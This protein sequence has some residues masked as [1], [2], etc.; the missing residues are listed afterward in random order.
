MRITRRQALEV[1]GAAVAAMIAGSPSSSAARRTILPEA[2][3]VFYGADVDSDAFKNFQLVVLDPAYQRSIAPMQQAGA[4][5][6]GYVSLGEIASNSIFR[7]RLPKDASLL[8]EN[9]QWAESFIVDV[10]VPSWRSFV[11]DTMIP[12][13]LRRGFDGLFL[14]TVDSITYAEQRA[15]GSIEAGA[16]LIRA[17][18]KAYPNTPIMLNRGYGVLEHVVNSIDAVLAESMLTTFDCTINAHRWTTQS[19]IDWQLAQLAPARNQKGLAIYALD[20][21]DPSDTATIQEIYRRE[22]ALGHR[23]YVATLKLDQVV[24][25]PRAPL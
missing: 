3:A 12:S 9:G 21:W 7:Q 20:Y 6:L 15:P 11:I 13:T 22:R 16:E 24:E 17:I 10:R 2:W 5:A 4:T 18:R 14:D 8:E 19:E 1:A 25:E 23:P